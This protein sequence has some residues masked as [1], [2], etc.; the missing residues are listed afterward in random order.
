MIVFIDDMFVYSKSEDDNMVHLKVVL[1]VLKE[2]QLFAEY[3]KCEFWLKFV[4][5]IGHIISSEG[6]EVDPKKTEAVNN[7]PKPLTSI[8]I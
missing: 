3:S 5:F 4:A 7:S 2:Y 8:D 1:Q 6:L